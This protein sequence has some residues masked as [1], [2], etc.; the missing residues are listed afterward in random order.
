MKEKL[1]KIF[2][3]LYSL[4]EKEEEAAFANILQIANENPDEIKQLVEELDQINL[5]YLYEALAIDTNKWSDFFLSEA[6][7][8]IEAA[9]N[10]DNPE[11]AIA[12]FDEFIFIELDDFKHS[13]ELV[14]LMSKELKH[15]NHAFKYWAM[16]IIADF[17]EEG[18]ILTLSLI[19]NM[20]KDSD[21]R[22]RNWAF[23]ILKGIK[24]NK[25]YKISI[26]DKIKFKLFK[27]YYFN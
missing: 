27:P 20:L 26:I 10:S 16:S 5:S 6:K 9:N 14:K 17:R 23:I 24:P 22:I 2:A 21:W 12:L 4:S 11:K 7:R 13:K 8:I 25:K 18:D 15:E 1:L 19:E 3:D